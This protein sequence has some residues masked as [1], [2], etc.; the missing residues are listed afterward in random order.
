M[1]NE[2][3]VTDDVRAL[4]DRLHAEAPLTDVHAHPSMK[5]YLFGYDLWKHKQSGWQFDPDSSRA[6]FAVLH[7][8]GVRVLWTAHYVIEEPFIRD[9]IGHPLMRAY[10]WWYFRVRRGIPIIKKVTAGSPYERLQE[11]MQSIEAQV[12]AGPPP[13]SGL[14]PAEYAKN[15]ADVKRIVGEGKLALVHTVEGAHALTHGAD[16]PLD[17]L[18]QVARRGVA[19]LTL[20]H[21]YWNT[22]AAQTDAMPHDTPFRSAFKTNDAQAT[23]TGKGKALLAKLKSLGMIVDISHCREDARTAIYDELNGEVPIVASHI[24]VR[25]RRSKSYNLRLDEDVD[26]IKESG[27]AVGVILMPYWLSEDQRMANLRGAKAVWQTVRDI[28]A[29]TGS[30]DHVMLGTDFDGFTDPPDDV[31][32][33]SFLWRITLR[34]YVGMK[35]EL[36]MSDADTQVALKKLLGG[37]A[38]RVLDTGWRGQP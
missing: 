28:H 16:D 14:P 15:P 1:A 9:A 8:G 31:P 36:G 3:A 10:I 33:A 21:F 11:I 5:S 7:K 37:N 18:E 38:Q 19:M 25:T 24:G 6:D 23:L 13:G 29:Q 20:D 12:A 32:D 27:G 26:R 2:A 22:Y 30:W 34:I 35:N 4:I 17:L